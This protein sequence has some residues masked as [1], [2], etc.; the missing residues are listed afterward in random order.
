MNIPTASSSAGS[1][2]EIEDGLYVALFRD[3]EPREHPDWAREKDAFGKSDDGKRFHFIFTI[4]D[5]DRKPV[6][7][8]DAESP[9][10]T[11]DLEAMT[12]NMSSHEKSNA[13]ALLKGILT[14][15]EFDLWLNTGKGDAEADTAWAAAAEK[16][17][18]RAVN[19]QVEHNEKGWP[20]VAATLG[21]AKAKAK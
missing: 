19:V 20:Q 2:P 8:Q 6:L 7:K 1:A 3:I 9:D 14:K 11:L 5:E 10:D 16:V 12:R 17:G 21:P 18:N 13:Y 15:A 4:L